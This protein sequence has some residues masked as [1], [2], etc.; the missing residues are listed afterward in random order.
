MQLGQCRQRQRNPRKRQATQTQTPSLAALSLFFYQPSRR[1]PLKLRRQW[2][3][4]PAQ[5]PASIPK[6]PP[7]R[8]DKNPRQS[9]H[10]AKQRLSHRQASTQRLQRLRA[11]PSAHWNKLAQPPLPRHPAPYLPPPLPGLWFPCLLLHEKP[12][13]QRN[14]FQFR[15]S[16]RS[17]FKTRPL[18]RTGQHSRQRQRFSWS[19]PP[20]ESLPRKKPIL[21]LRLESPRP[22]HSRPHQHQHQH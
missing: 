5:V 21:K 20:S 3:H 6:Q 1:K 9:H 8:P 10:R 18:T 11:H 16:H 14:P 17:G 4:C 15:H 12:L 13:Q 22:A 19:C 2:P 7:H